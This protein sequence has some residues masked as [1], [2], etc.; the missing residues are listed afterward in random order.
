MNETSHINWVSMTDEAVIKP[1][2]VDMSPQ[3]C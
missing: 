3:Q 2:G 1:D